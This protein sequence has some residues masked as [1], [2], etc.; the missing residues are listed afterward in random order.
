MAELTPEFIADEMEA[1]VAECQGKKKLKPGDLNKEM[2]AKFGPE[3]NRQVC[4][5]AIRLLIESGRCVY[6]YFGGSFI[7][8][9]H[10]EGAAMGDGGSAEEAKPAPAPTAAPAAVAPRPKLGGKKKKKKGLA[11]RLGRTSSGKASTPLRPQPVPK[12]APCSQGCPQNNDVR[13]FLTSIAQT[14]KM[15]RSYDESFE[16]A[17][18]ILTETN[19]FPAICGRVCSHTCEAKCNR[20]EKDNP[21]AINN[22]ERYIGDFG[23]EKGLKFKGVENSKDK[24]VAVVGAGPQG[25]AAAFHLTKKGYGV[26][27]FEAL[28]NPGGVLYYD[29]PARRLPRKVAVAEMQ[30][31]FDL[32]VTFKAGCSVGNDTS[33]EDL[34][35][36]FDSVFIAA[37]PKSKLKEGIPGEGTKSGVYTSLGFFNAVN[38]GEKLELAG[39]V[40]IAGAGDAAVES[41]IMAKRLGNNVTVLAKF[42]KDN[43]LAEADLIAEAEKEGVSFIF[44]STLFEI[45]EADNKVSAI[46]YKADGGTK[47]MA[48]GTIIYA[49]TLE[50]KEMM[51]PA[52][53]LATSKEW[54]KIVGELGRGRTAAINLDC[55]LQGNEKPGKPTDPIVKPDNMKL[56]HYPE[57]PRNEEI[58]IETLDQLK[59]RVEAAATLSASATR[60]EAASCMSCGFCFDCEKC[61]SFCQAGAV[62]KGE[63]GQIYTYKHELCTGCKKCAEECPCGFLDMV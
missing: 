10:E 63:K 2:K 4:K 18:D 20:K 11:G 46:K 39:D 16:L 6:T 30:K 36:E 37:G 53:S 27:L 34:K 14:V 58:V 49:V 54:L 31:I 19:P 44:E 55:E 41:A 22:V 57:A 1:I 52:D 15:D 40:V 48:A 38:S 25:L 32:G 5:K 60:D 56:G 33:L 45:H 23:I 8:M 29:I 24:K 13:A 42:A 43:M 9:P 28:K 7:E 3:A 61:W 12:I 51:V 47:E 26:T 35:S 62:A 17:W 21:V 50:E 59:E